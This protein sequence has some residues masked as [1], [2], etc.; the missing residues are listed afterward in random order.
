MTVQQHNWQPDHTAAPHTM[1]TDLEQVL[2]QG[3]VWRGRHWQSRDDQAL[4]TGHP[5]LD[6]LL[7]EQGWP[8]N[9]LTEILYQQHGIGEMHLLVPTLAAL[10]RQ[11]RWIM[12]IAPPFVPNAAALEAAGVDT[13]RLLVVQPGSVRDLLWTI[14]ESLR[15]GTCSAV[16]A[17]PQQLDIRTVRRLQLAA[18]TGSSLGFLFRPEQQS[19]ESSPAALRLHLS[20]ASRGQTEVTVLKQRGGWGHAPAQMDLGLGT[21][22]PATAPVT[23]AVADVIQGPWEPR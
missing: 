9:A 3:Q 6:T 14:E 11:E 15:S 4:S 7:A 20:A 17:W 18:E 22:L 10:S 23:S 19:D 2:E 1:T 16:L 5:A 12:L 13:S 21:Q 8:Q